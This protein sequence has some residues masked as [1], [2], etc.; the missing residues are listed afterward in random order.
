MNHPAA[1]SGEFNPQRLNENSNIYINPPTQNVGDITG[2]EISYS[3]L[4]DANR[5]NLLTRSMDGLI[6]EYSLLARNSSDSAVHGE[7]WASEYDE[8]IIVRYNIFEDNYGSGIIFLKKNGTCSPESPGWIIHGNVFWHTSSFVNGDDDQYPN[9]VFGRGNENEAGEGCAQSAGD[10]TGLRFYNNTIVGIGNRGDAHNYSTDKI[11][12]GGIDID[13][14]TS[15]NIVKNN[16]WY[17]N[18][19][20]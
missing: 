18:C 16:L 11:C 6:V 12:G 10:V 1:S 2:W 13:D 15:D 14:D 8:D 3:Y 7:A 5:V 19:I 9:G 20:L 17:S 4:H